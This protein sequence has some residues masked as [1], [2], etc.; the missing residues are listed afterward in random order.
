[1]RIT[2]Q[3]SLEH[4]VMFLSDP[5]SDEDVP[6]DTGQDIVTST[7]NSIA[8]Q[9]RPYFDGAALVTLASEKPTE[10]L[11]PIFNGTITCKSKVLSLSDSYRFN[12]CL[13][14]VREENVEIQVWR[15]INEDDDIW[16]RVSKIEEY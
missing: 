9:V 11:L 4:P 3:L 16:I 7:G 2:I 14:P 8:V 6:P 13:I 5:Y 15:A 1:M 10:A 12:Y